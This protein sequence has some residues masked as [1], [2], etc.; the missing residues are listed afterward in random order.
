MK[1]RK[2]PVEV[3]AI[4]WTGKNTREVKRWIS[5]QEA[6]RTL[7]AVVA[8]FIPRRGPG[9]SETLW[10]NVADEEWSDDVTAAVYD[11]LHE[12]Y[13]GVKTGQFIICGTKGEFYPCDADGDVPLNYEEV[14]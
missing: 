14:R 2:K 10:K 12:T 11:Y 13:V 3:E 8:V 9:M 4:R 1:F 6:A 5:E 7:A